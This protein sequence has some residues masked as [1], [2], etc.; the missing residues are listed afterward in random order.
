MKANKIK[1]SFNLIINKFLSLTINYIWFSR[2]NAEKVRKQLNKKPFSL[3]GL[4]MYLHL[5]PRLKELFLKNVS[6]V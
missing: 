2:Q 1:Q 6:F 5:N 3:Y 4:M